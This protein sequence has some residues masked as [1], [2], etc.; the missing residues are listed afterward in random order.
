MAQPRPQP[1]AG[2]DIYILENK[3]RWMRVLHPALFLLA[4]VGPRFA[5]ACIVLCRLVRLRAKVFVGIAFSEW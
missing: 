1:P 3:K 5:L 2:R 4:C